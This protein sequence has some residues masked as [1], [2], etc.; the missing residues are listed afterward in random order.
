M[1]NLIKMIRDHADL[2][3]VAYLIAAYRHYLKYRTDD[4]G[5]VFE[6]AEPWM[7]KED[8]TLTAS[9]NP[10]DFLGL[11][12]FKSTDLKQSPEFVKLYAG[13]VENI[14][15]KGAMATLETILK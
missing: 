12:A 2:T 5:A 1:P 8:E 6:I 15:S 9:D 4:N 13:M 3:R 11:S 10:T 14:R 7:T